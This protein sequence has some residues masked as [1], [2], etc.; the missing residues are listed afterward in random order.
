MKQK[1]KKE[2]ADRWLQ[3]FDTL[4]G[5]ESLSQEIQVHADHFYFY[6]SLITSRA[7]AEVTISTA[8]I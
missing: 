8:T 3:T 4:N 1:N 7:I 5:L 2:K 6:D